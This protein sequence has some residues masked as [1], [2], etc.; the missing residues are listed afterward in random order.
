MKSGAIMAGA[1]TLSLLTNMG[2]SALIAADAKPAEDIVITKDINLQEE[3]QPILD[4]INPFATARFFA[5]RGTVQKVTVA[6]NGLTYIA[7]EDAA[8]APAVFVVSK[9]TYIVGNPEAKAG[10]SAVKV[11]DVVTGYYDATLPMIMIY[12]PQYTTEVLVVGEQEENIKVDVFN[13]ELVSSDKMLKLML[14]PDTKVTSKDGTAYEGEL[15]NRKLLVYYT[16]STRSIPAQTS[17]TQ[18]IVLSEE[19]VAPIGQPEDTGT[20][21]DLAD[22]GIAVGSLEI[23]VNNQVIQAPAAYQGGHSVMVP[24]RAMAEAIGYKVTWNQTKQQVGL[25]MDSGEDVTLL[26]GQDMVQTAGHGTVKLEE[27]AALK[28]GVTYVPLKFFKDVLKMNN[29]Y[30]FEAQIVVDN[31]ELMH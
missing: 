8:G 26:I 3:T 11:G 15:A 19:E 27:A 7:V 14:S 29:A 31:G 13:K 2:T 18:I 16:V 5:F 30:I 10:D 17:P 1:L 4:M 12:P 6:E 28:E 21:T 24:L 20:E 25:S 9:D 23:V 22:L